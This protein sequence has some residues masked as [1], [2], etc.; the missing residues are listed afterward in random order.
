[1]V[2]PLAVGFMLLLGWIVAVAVLSILIYSLAFLVLWAPTSGPGRSVH[3]IE[4]SAAGRGFNAAATA[5]RRPV[6]PVVTYGYDS[7]AASKRSLCTP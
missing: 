3:W 4:R 7:V 1:M 5:R 6:L 2:E